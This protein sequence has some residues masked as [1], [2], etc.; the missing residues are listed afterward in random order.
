M[1]LGSRHTAQRVKTGPPLHMYATLEHQTWTLGP[2]TAYCGSICNLAPQSALASR[3]SS[4][5]PSAHATGTSYQVRLPAP[6]PN[7]PLP[8]A[9]TPCFLEKIF[10]YAKHSCEFFP[11]RS[12]IQ[13]NPSTPTRRS[14]RRA[15][16]AS[17]RQCAMA[18]APELDGRN[19]RGTHRLD[20]VSLDSA[21]PEQPRARS[22]ARLHACN[23]S[24][25][26]S[27]LPTTIS[28]GSSS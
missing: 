17:V 19:R 14:S 24:P 16:F 11:A 20:P 15:D 5:A 2:T 10:C 7:L 1:Q 3:I 9:F 4:Q 22:P 8:Q 23:I 18:P 13:L 28:C 25:V 27:T 26:R 6:P 12:L 21:P